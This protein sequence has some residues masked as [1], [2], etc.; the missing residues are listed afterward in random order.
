M[1]N[2]VK[3]SFPDAPMG[4]LAPSSS[5]ADSVLFD[6]PAKSSNP[7]KEDVAIHGSPSENL[8]W[9]VNV[10]NSVLFTK[11]LKS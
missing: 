9:S 2:A 3:A 4:E 11:G 5:A 8:L 1:W 10:D 7:S 6:P